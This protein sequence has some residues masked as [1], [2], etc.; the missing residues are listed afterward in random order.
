MSCEVSILAD[1]RAKSIRIEK[2]DFFVIMNN[3]NLFC[4]NSY[5]IPVCCNRR[6]RRVVVLNGNFDQ[7][8]KSIMVLLYL[9]SSEQMVKIPIFKENYSF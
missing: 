5:C 8:S 9:I 1:L 4:S 3:F 6:G 2:G 7:Y